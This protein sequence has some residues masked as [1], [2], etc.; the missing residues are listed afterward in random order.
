MQNC[1]V[2]NKFTSKFCCLIFQLPSCF[3]DAFD[4]TVINNSLKMPF[5]FK[6]KI[7][8]FL[9]AFSIFI[10]AVLKF[11]NNLILMDI[12]FHSSYWPFD[13]HFQTTSYNFINTKIAHIISMIA[14]SPFTFY[15]FFLK[16]TNLSTLS[17]ILYW[18]YK[19]DFFLQV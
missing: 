11:H 8:F 16:N 4:A 10:S 3:C 19:S 5:F 17:P 7:F 15:H 18:T 14:T 2:Q 6:P 9:E 13:W 1:I 12:F